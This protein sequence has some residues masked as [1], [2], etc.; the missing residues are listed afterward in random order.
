MLISCL[1]C[2][3]IIGLVWRGEKVMYEWKR[4]DIPHKGWEC[5]DVIDLGEDADENEEIS[6]EKCEMCGFEEIRY[7]HIMVHPEYDGQLRVGCV[8]AEKMS[9]D[10]VNPR[11]REKTLKNKVA[12]KKTFMKKPWSYKEEKG[13][14][15]KKYKGEYITMMKGR[16]G[17]WGIFFAK[18]SIWNFNGKK[19]LT[20]EEAENVAFEV[21]EKYHT[22]RKQR[23]LAE[24]WEYDM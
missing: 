19:I 2:L 5:I 21:F 18:Q 13:T 7:V 17:S 9:E 1:T 15:S 8:C 4:K 24:M 23:Q 22:T 11:K 6:Y 14:Y 16:Y 20:F 12:R 3:D 10:Y